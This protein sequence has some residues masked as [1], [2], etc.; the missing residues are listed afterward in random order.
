[1][2]VCHDIEKREQFLKGGLKREDL[3]AVRADPGN[4]V[5]GH[6]PEIFIHADL[7]DPEAAGTAPAETEFSS[8]A[9]TILCCQNSFISLVYSA[10]THLEIVSSQRSKVER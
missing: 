2:V 10:G 6:A 7:A 9:D 5:A 8:A 1:M 3:A 4:V